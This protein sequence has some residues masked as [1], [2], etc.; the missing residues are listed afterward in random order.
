MYS[1]LYPEV[2]PGP[3]IQCYVSHH[4][5]SYKTFVKGIAG[6]LVIKTLD[7]SLTP[8]PG[9]GMEMDSWL[10]SSLSKKEKIGCRKF[11]YLSH[12]IYIYMFSIFYF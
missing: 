2:V 4:A 12:H 9:L 5:C 7:I 3:W 6:K 1:L 8:A 10:L 11:S